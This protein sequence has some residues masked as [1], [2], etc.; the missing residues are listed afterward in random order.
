MSSLGN[1][2]LLINYLVSLIDS[3]LEI[4]RGN[5]RS[6]VSTHR[7]GCLSYQPCFSIDLLTY[8][9]ILWNIRLT[10]KIFIA[11]SNSYDSDRHF[12]F[13]LRANLVRPPTNWMPGAEIKLIVS[14]SKMAYY[15]TSTKMY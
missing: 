13:R 6:T 14:I 7:G 10:W 2:Y 1:Y 3:N 12:L 8:L 11:L 4:L 5:Y 9:I 15:Y